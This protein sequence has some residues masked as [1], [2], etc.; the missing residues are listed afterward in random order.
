MA[1]QLTNVVAFANPFTDDRLLNPVSNPTISVLDNGT[2]STAPQAGPI[3]GVVNEGALPGGNLGGPVSDNGTFSISL[4]NAT[5]GKLV[6]AGVD[7]TLGGTVADVYGNLT[8]TQVS[9][10]YNWSYNL[11][12][13]SVDLPGQEPDVFAVTV[14]N[15]NGNQASDSLVINRIDDAPTARND[16]DALLVGSSSVATGNVITGTATTSGAAGSD[17]PG[18]DGGIITAIASFGVPGSSNSSGKLS[19][20][21]LYGVLTIDANGN[22]FYV[23]NPGSPLGVTDSFTYTLTDGNGDNSSAT[24]TINVNNANR[25]YTP[26]P[27]DLEILAKDVV[28]QDFYSEGDLIAAMPGFPYK[29]DKIWD[30]VNTGLFAFGLTAAN[31]PSIL[32]F[33]G[34]GDKFDI[35]DDLNI[36]GI[37]YDQFTANRDSLR[38]WIFKQGSSIPPVIT[39]HSLGGALA[40]WLAADVTANGGQRLSEVVTFNSPGITGSRSFQNASIGADAFM[41]AL[42]GKVTHYITSSDIVSLGGSKYIHGDFKLFD[43][44]SSPGDS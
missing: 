29:I 44:G 16:I 9:G 33:R 36:N 31:A 23:R 35:W 15:S 1:S 18:A 2:Q 20:K 13:S 43:Y 26:S 21:G 10:V 32:V 38:D 22:Y 41:A 28:Y 42:A 8:V 30:D 4:G 39:G 7:V 5:L 40:Q 14:T 25:P 6:V 17:R 11:T 19:V 12:S 27:E 37:G 3:D 34:T 24:L